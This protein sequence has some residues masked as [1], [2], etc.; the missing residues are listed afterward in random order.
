M[1]SEI[2]LYVMIY[3]FIALVEIF[4]LSDI[5]AY[6]NKG[7]KHRFVDK[8]KLF[9]GENYWSPEVSFIPIWFQLY[10]SFHTGEEGKPLKFN[11]SQKFDKCDSCGKLRTG[12]YGER[13]DGWNFY[14]SLKCEQED[15]ENAEISDMYPEEYQYV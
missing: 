9:V 4:L 12:D 3:P 8:Y 7:M 6:I 5:Y 2:I 14:C 11:D 10:N 15:F 13:F 1:D